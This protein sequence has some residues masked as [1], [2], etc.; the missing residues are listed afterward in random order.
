MRLVVSAAMLMT[1]LLGACG[2]AP[3][4]Y[5]APQVSSGGRIAI[6]V[7]K[8]EVRE[9]SLPAY[10]RTEE[11]WTQSASGAL[12][13]DPGVLW[14]D[15]PARGLTQEVSTHLAGVT[16]ARVA[17][18]PWP[19]EDLPDARV[20]LRLERMVA[21]PDGR[22]HLAGQYYIASLIGGADRSGSFDVSAPIAPDSGAPG[23][24][25][26]RAAA[27]RDLARL[28]ASRGI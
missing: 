21:G 25:A 5:A 28:I 8:V 9:V 20:H 1:L 13:S 11:I 19:F 10:A 12:A 23:I 7:G 22:F 27:A 2:A 17:A 24:A 26:A 16:G 6:S 15:D 18:E 14:A 4:R 3:V